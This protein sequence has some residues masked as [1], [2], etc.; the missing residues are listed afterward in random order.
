MY[1][2]AQLTSQFKPVLPVKDLR[3]H[4]RPT[5]KFSIQEP[6][7]FSKVKAGKK[8]KIKEIDPGDLMRT[9][10]DLS[11]KDNSKFVLI[12]YSEEYPPVIQNIG[13]ASLI[14]DY[15]RKKDDRD[16]SYV[17]N[18]KENG[19]TVLLE[20]L[21]ISPFFGFGDVKPGDSDAFL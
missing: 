2:K 15:Y 19:T 13:M 16:N 4:H 21:D 12:E 3:Y 10:K 1:F 17:P 14:H 5:I 7:I 8:K 11:L 18:Q 9:P 20:P 6:I